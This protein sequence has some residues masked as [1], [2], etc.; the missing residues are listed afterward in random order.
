MPI[1]PVARVKVVMADGY[2]SPAIN[3]YDT[4]SSIASTLNTASQISRTVWYT[5]NIRDVNSS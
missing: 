5:I 4:C 1:T 3:Q 2:G